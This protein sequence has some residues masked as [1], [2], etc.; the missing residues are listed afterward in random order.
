MD[1][2]RYSKVAVDLWSFSV[3]YNHSQTRPL[4][5]IL[6]EC[7]IRVVGFEILNLPEVRSLLYGPHFVV[8]QRRLAATGKV[9]NESCR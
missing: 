5:L 2:S 8:Q 7:R 6:C 3:D 1:L 9:P 4:R